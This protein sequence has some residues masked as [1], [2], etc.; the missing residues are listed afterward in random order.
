M[1]CLLLKNI[2]G[3]KEVVKTAHTEAI[4]NMDHD[5]EVPTLVDVAYDESEGRGIPLLAASLEV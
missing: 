3:G 5:D 2:R 1:S 4:E